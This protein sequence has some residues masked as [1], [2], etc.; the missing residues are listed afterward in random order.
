MPKRLVE[1]E[2]GDNAVLTQYAARTPTLTGSTVPHFR[3]A[4]RAH[5]RDVSL[6]AG[7]LSRRQ[8]ARAVRQEFLMERRCSLHHR[9]TS[10]GCWLPRSKYA[11][12]D[13]SGHVSVEYDGEWT[14]DVAK[15]CDDCFDRPAGQVVVVLAD[16]IAIQDGAL[17]WSHP[18]APSL[19][20]LMLTMINQPSD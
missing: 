5:E 11:K 16:Q 17:P 12:S 8:A 9:G 20:R 15:R 14:D 4:P 6:L 19:L 1:I 10:A 18:A 3:R 13:D 2:L 7:Q